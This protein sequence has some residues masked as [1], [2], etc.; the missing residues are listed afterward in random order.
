M[1][2]NPT[3]ESHAYS[4]QRQ[5]GRLT[6]QQPNISLI[7]IKCVQ[8]KRRYRYRVAVAFGNRRK[9]YFVCVFVTNLRLMKG[10]N[11]CL[12]IG[13]ADCWI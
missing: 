5:P 6:S 3:N 8:I 7:Y 11:F 13:H 10:N 1:I 4:V 9:I 12:E 2:Y